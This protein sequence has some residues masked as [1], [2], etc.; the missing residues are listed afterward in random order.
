MAC[1]RAGA[2]YAPPLC[3]SRPA[4]GFVVMFDADPLKPSNT[5]RLIAD[6]LP[7]TQAFL[8]SRT[9]PDPAM[10]AAVADP[11]RQPYV[12]FPASHMP[13]GRRVVNH[14]LPDARP[15]LFILLD[16]TWPEAGKMFRKSPWLTHF[17][18]LSLELPTVSQY[19][20]RGSHG[21]G[22]HCTAEVAAALLFQTG[23]H[24]TA[25]ALMAHFALF[26][27]RYL[28]GK[29]HAPRGLSPSSQQ[30]GNKTRTIIPSTS[31]GGSDEFTGTGGAA[32]A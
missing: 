11:D 18:V 32:A 15:P 23:D 8:W 6:I 2:V 16:G 26:R 17:P 4:A 27:H 24:A 29:S 12:V 3:C 9:Q 5:G 22:H 13:G 19:G 7:A 14:I 25:D 20:L 1:Y 31:G 28:A 10:L 21:E 30:K